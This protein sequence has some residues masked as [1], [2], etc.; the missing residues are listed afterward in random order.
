ML[1]G[2]RQPAEATAVAI[3]WPD[4][5]RALVRQYRDNDFAAHTP[6]SRMYQRPSLRASSSE[7]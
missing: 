1:A 4:E 3:P 6:L 7:S 5:P 2:S